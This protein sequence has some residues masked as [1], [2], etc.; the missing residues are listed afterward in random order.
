M[1]QNA[2]AIA[3]IVYGVLVLAVLGHCTFLLPF[4]ITIWKQY[5]N[6]LLSLSAVLILNLFAASYL[7]LRR[8][9][10]RDTGDKL[11]HLEKQLRGS[12]TISEE[13]TE[14]IKQRK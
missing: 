9:G 10:L 12:R 7:L 11:S 4:K 3:V 14:R 2:L 5:A 8:L 1:I 13:L 6:V